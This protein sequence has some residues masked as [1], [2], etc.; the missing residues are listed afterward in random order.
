MRTRREIDLLNKMSRFSCIALV[1]LRRLISDMCSQSP[2]SVGYV[3]ARTIWRRAVLALGCFGASQCR[4]VCVMKMGH[5]KV[6][7]SKQW[8]KI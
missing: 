8:M 3:L 6:G 5:R 7:Q 1:A 2:Q 4:Q